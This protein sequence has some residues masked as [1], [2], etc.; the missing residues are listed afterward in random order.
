MLIFK[1]QNRRVVFGLDVLHFNRFVN[2]SVSDYYVL[3][4]W[5]CYSVY[6]EVS[7]CIK[8]KK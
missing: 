1:F 4:Y 2:E 5:W 6:C 7:L 3:P 8:S